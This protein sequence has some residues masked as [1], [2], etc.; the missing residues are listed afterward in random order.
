MKKSKRGG[1]GGRGKSKRRRTSI[2]AGAIQGAGGKS[3]RR[4]ARLQSMYANG[5]VS[6]T[7]SAGVSM[8]QWIARTRGQNRAITEKRVLSNSYLAGGVGT[9]PVVYQ[10]SDPPTPVGAGIQGLIDRINSGI[11]FAQKA[12]DTAQTVHDTISTGF[13]RAKEAAAMFTGNY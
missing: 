6:K 5:N 8:N 4:A 9:I 12:H 3:Q 10:H 13:D 11:Q 1:G 7:A 2:Q